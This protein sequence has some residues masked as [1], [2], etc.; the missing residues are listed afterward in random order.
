MSRFWRRV[1]T[2][3]SLILIIGIGSIFLWSKYFE[4]KPQVMPKMVIMTTAIAHKGDNYF[5]ST[6]IKYPEGLCYVMSS[7]F[8]VEIREN[9]QTIAYVRI[10]CEPVPEDVS[11][12]QP[13]RTFD[14]LQ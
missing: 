12:L 8:S 4:P 5:S 14:N 1:S 9:G 2:F 11:E 3:I 13:P 7:S 6:S 10:T